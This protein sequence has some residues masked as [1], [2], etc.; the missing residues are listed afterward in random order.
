MNK[1]EWKNKWESVIKYCD[2]SLS[3][4]N[5]G[6]LD[7][8]IKIQAKEYLEE[9]LNT[10]DLNSLINICRIGLAEMIFD[11]KDKYN[12][13]EYLF[14]NEDIINI[15]EAEQALKDLVDMLNE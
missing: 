11:L 6:N 2:E 14:L 10:T 3:L 9:D 1:S 5:C 15:G 7:K 8:T 12:S 4:M 13:G